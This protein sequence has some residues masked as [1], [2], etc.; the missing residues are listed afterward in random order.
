MADGSVRV[1][2]AASTEL[3]E[4]EEWYARL[5]SGG[6]YHSPKYVRTLQAHLE[7]EAELLV[8]REGEKLVYYPY[9]RR[10]IEGPRSSDTATAGTGGYSDIVSS[11]YYGGPL[12]S[13]LDPTRDRKFVRR[14]AQCFS[15]YCLDERIVS[16]FV[17][18]DPQLRNDVAVGD[19]MA[20]RYDRPTVHV[21]LTQSDREMWA[22]FEG[23]NRTSIRKAVACGIRVVEAGADGIGEFARVYQR[24]MQR[25]G[26]QGHY[27]FDERTFELF[28]E[29]LKE[30]FLLFLAYHEERPIG[31]G[32]VMRGSG[33]AHDFLRATLPQFWSM[34]PNNLLLFEEI[35]SCKR[36]G[37]R[38][39]DL[40][41]GRPGVFEFKRA[42]SSARGAFH[43]AKIVHLPKVYRMLTGLA[44]DA[45]ADTSGGFFPSYR[46]AGSA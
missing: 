8:Y 22:G 2:Q 6:V 19:V 37:D 18:F 43:V 12:V 29:Q 3:E 7:A 10:K 25:K 33:V 31:G 28:A 30:R 38:V 34:Q 4:W 35:Q 41:G 32:V 24:E 40:Q 23:R 17:R 21:D 15:Q 42:F 1:L 14:F 44:E 36:R 9:F 39:F 11:W 13:G 46:A 26:A 20:V 16:E 27:L 5:E 45:G